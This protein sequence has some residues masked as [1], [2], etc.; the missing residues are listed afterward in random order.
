MKAQALERVLLTVATGALL[1]CASTPQPLVPDRYPDLASYQRARE[2]LVREERSRRLSST[3]VLTSEEEAASRTLDSMRKAELERTRDHF[4]PAHSY[5]LERTKRAIEESPVLEVMRRLPKGG[6]L[7]VHGSWGYDLRWAIAQAVQREDAWIFVGDEGP[8]VR[9]SIRFS[10]TPPEGA[11]RPL[12]E[13]RQ[14]APDARAFD[15]ELHRSITLGEEE[16]GLGDVWPEFVRCFRR[17]FGLFEDP[18]IRAGH[19]RRMLQTLIA[20][21]VQYVEFRGW[22]ADPELVREAQRQDAD[23]GVKFIPAAGRSGT[24]ERV[25]E[26]LDRVVNE[27]ARDPGRV[28]GFDLVEEED[29]THGTLFFMEELLAARREAEQEGFS[30]PF[31]L[32]SGETRQAKGDNLHDAILLGSPRIGHGLALARHPYLMELVKQRGTAI[33]VCPISNQV[34]GYV[35]D[36]RSHPAVAYLNAGI[37]IVLA[38]D[39]PGVMRQTLS[40]DFYAAFMAWELELRD[41]KQL[42]M[43]SLQHSA[44]DADEK[45]RALAAWQA[46]WTTFVAWLNAGPGRRRPRRSTAAR[47]RHGGAARRLPARLG[48]TSRRSRRWRGPSRAAWS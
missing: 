15:D 4:A 43:D 6:I 27:R 33:E 19:W 39:D 14:A 41:L 21:N 24:R 40:H 1:G 13:L 48:G 35:P 31:F 26:A 5:L 45:R 3:L 22:P 36:L 9:G 2:R 28:V 23:F 47:L 37:P 16:A 17:G 32:H 18:E 44:M 42:A 10:A 29:R 20:E 11:W 7:H 38:P 30:L 12:A 8:V 34:L 25:K 46:R